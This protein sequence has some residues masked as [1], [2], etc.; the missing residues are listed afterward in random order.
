MIRSIS[1]K[2]FGHFSDK[3][4]YFTSGIN[5]IYAANEEGKTT[6]YSALQ[7]LLLGFIPAGRKYTYFPWEGDE[8]YLRAELFDGRVV[9][10][11]ITSGVSA[12]V[13]E[14][15]MVKALA[16]R[17]LDG[18]SRS[19][20]ENF[21]LL[22]ADSLYRLKYS[23]VDEIIEEHLE[24]L[25]MDSGPSY[26]SL[27]GLLE[28]RK[29]EIYK[30][31]GSNFLLYSL[32]ER[33]ASLSREELLRKRDQE[34]Y[35]IKKRELEDY[36]FTRKSSKDQ[37]DKLVQIKKR[38]S[39]IDLE[40]EEKA[41]ELLELQRL[42]G[43]K[44]S[45][46]QRVFPPLYLGLGFFLILLL[47][48]LSRVLFS[49]YSLGLVLAIL[50]GVLFYIFLARKNKEAEAELLQEAGFYSRADFEESYN[51]QSRLDLSTQGLTQEKIRVLEELSLYSDSEELVPGEDYMQLRI[52]LA[53]LE[54]RL[55]SPLEGRQELEA[56]RRDLVDKYNHYDI[57]KGLIEASYDEYKRELLP[58]ILE[59]TSSYLR[60]FTQGS[61]DRVF[62]DGQGGFFIEKK[63]YPQE[64]MDSMSKGFR[65]QFYLALRL[66]I[67]DIMNKGLPVFYDEAF[68][69]WDE[70]RLEAT[71]ETIS[72]L[73]RQQFIFTC[74][75]SE[76]ELYERILGIKRIAF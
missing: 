8:L 14:G 56:R 47:S 22:E 52:E 25:Y 45:L 66:A 57:L 49:S 39:G 62:R 26:S 53:G 69:N 7:A 18:L 15:Q 46:S 13:E 61:Y 6:L 33:L 38:L 16:N 71:L 34:V 3:K 30:K 58:E 32:D 74:K 64:V 19:Y 20:V 5:L 51:I 35:K 36:D 76:A 55:K 4:I 1:L 9:S 28:D 68:S 67:I 60:G 29:R 42:E 44:D 43:L 10:R 65:S 41:E 27:L 48:Y 54:E 70:E 11:K 12:F 23:T 72:L 17:P 31:R 21:H 73:G 40:L 2:P 50:I 75:K 63:G 59:K 24:K 37:E